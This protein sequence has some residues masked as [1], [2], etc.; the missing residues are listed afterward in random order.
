V[1]S[2]RYAKRTGGLSLALFIALALRSISE[3][4]LTLFGYGT[5]FFAHMLLL[6]TLSAGAS[7]RVHAT[8]PQPRHVYGV[9]A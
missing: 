4:P 1:L 2:L 8:Q 5:E 6:V 3:V 7:M 9:P